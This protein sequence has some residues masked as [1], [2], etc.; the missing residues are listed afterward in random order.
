MPSFMFLQDYSEPHKEYLDNL[1]NNLDNDQKED[2]Y[3]LSQLITA[4]SGNQPYM[5]QV[6]VGSVVMNRMQY[7]NLPMYDV[8]FMKNAF[9]VAKNGKID[10]IPTQQCRYAA[11]QAYFGAKPV[12]SARFFNAKHITTSWAATHCTLYKII[13]N[14]AFYI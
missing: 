8:I 4:E 2:I 3:L 6:A 12:S 11:I 10:K 13:G 7:Y 14:H 5:G 1:Y 9:S